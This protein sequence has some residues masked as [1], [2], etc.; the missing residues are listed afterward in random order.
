MKF[1]VRMKDPDTLGDAC[2]EAAQA[3]LKSVQGIDNDER[4]S[5]VEGRAASLSEFAAKWFKYGEY[6]TVELDTEAGTAI[7]VPRGN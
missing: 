1:R 4:E 2:T 7:V 3:A 5:L 6:V